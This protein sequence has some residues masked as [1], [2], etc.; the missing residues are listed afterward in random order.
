MKVGDKR[1]GCG[2]HGCI[3]NPPKK[4]SIA[5]TAMCNCLNSLSFRNKVA[6]TRRIENLERQVEVLLLEQ[7]NE[8]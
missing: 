4:G 8:T 7:E 2:N 5:T 3:I 6:L 1:I